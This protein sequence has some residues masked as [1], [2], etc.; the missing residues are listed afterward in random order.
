MKAILLLAAFSVAACGEESLPQHG[1]APVSETDAPLVGDL[2]GSG[3]QIVEMNEVACDAGPEVYCDGF[4]ALYLGRA[5][6]PDDKGVIMY[7]CPGTDEPSDNWK[8]RKVAD[9]G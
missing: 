8:C 9:N 7:E 5:S 2:I 4:D 1:L 3:L 6:G